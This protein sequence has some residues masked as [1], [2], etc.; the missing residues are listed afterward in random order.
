M[1]HPDTNFTI[2]AATFFPRGH[3]YIFLSWLKDPGTEG[4]RVNH[5]HSSKL[6][7]TLDGYEYVTALEL[8][9]IA[10]REKKTMKVSL[11]DIIHYFKS[12]DSYQTIEVHLPQLI[13]LSYTE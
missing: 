6:H 2:L 12:I 10:G 4:G 3:A 11:N 8:M 5:F 9:G 13:P 7:S 1:L